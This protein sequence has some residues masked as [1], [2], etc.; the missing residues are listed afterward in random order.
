MHTSSVVRVGAAGGVGVSA[1]A[2][3]EGLLR[4][5]TAEK[6]L[7]L[8]SLLLWPLPPLPLP[9]PLLRLPGGLRLRMRSGALLPAGGLPGRSMLSLLLLLPPPPLLLL[10]LLLSDSPLRAAR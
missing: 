7:L 9:L 2:A 1:A 8:L 10:L 3:W 4:L 5:S 6:L